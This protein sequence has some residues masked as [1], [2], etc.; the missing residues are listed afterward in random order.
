MA[1][2][3]SPWAP[4]PV[5]LSFVFLLSLIELLFK[6]CHLSLHSCESE[7]HFQV[8]CHRESF[9]LGYSFRFGKNTIQGI[10]RET[11]ERLLES[12]RANIYGSLY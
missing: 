8:S 9:A 11:W 2:S 6:L 1:I 4:L 5:I 10:I 12:T 7:I 3:F